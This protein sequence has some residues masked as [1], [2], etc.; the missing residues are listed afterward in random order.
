MTEPLV[1][2]MPVVPVA[3]MSSLAV[4]ALLAPLWDRLPVA[5]IVNPV[6]AAVESAA[7]VPPD[8]VKS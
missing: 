5:E 2:V 1:R 7:M 3:E 6:P 4:I 8:C